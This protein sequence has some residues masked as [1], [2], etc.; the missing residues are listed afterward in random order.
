MIYFTDVPIDSRPEVWRNMSVYLV[1]CEFLISPRRETWNG[2]RGRS[3]G[4]DVSSGNRT[5]AARNVN[6]IRVGDRNRKKF[7]GGSFGFS[8]PLN[9]SGLWPRRPG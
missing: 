7:H 6:L 5:D 2:G 4:D 8:F 1:E 9:Y 3:E